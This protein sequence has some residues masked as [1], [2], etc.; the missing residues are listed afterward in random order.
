[1]S[2]KR[3]SKES[4]IIVGGVCAL[5]F[6]VGLALMFLNN[7]LYGDGD[8]AAGKLWFCSAILTLCGG[9]GGVVFAAEVG[10]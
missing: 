3:S 4:A 5:A 6:F 7:T 10:G 2:I 9:V 8:D 1:M